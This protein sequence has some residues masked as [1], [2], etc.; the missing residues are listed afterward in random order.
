MVSNLRIF[1]KITV[2]LRGY[3]T[4]VQHHLMPIN[5]S[6]HIGR[7]VIYLKIIEILSDFV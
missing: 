1:S 5:C 7:S 4:F 6:F 2:Y 3:P